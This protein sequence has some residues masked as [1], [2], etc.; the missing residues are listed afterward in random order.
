MHRPKEQP[1]T[2]NLVEQV[3]EVPFYIPATGPST[4]P[5]RNLK[6]DDC[7]AIFDSHGDIGAS[8]GGPDGLYCRDTR[9][10]GHLELLLN[11]TQLLLLGSNV[12]DDNA[13]LTVD[14]TNPDIYF[15][16][17]LVLPKDTLHLVRT[18]FLWN[19][20][21][22]QRVRIHNHGDR[23]VHCVVGMSYSSDFADLFEVR[24]MRRAKR[25]SAN[26]KI[27]GD[28]QVQL[29]YWGL[30]DEL[31]C[32]DLSFAPPPDR[33]S[34]A[35]ASYT[36][37][38]AP[39]EA[40]AID[41]T[42]ECRNDDRHPA[43]HPFRRG[44]RAALQER[45]LATRSTTTI[46]TSHDIFNEM[47]C[48]S[49]SD[50]AMLVTHTEQGPYPYA[51]IPWY[52]TTFGR[53]G[54]ITA[55]QTLW[56]CPDIARG[57]LRRLAALQAQAFDPLA[58]AEPGKILHEMR[59]GEMANL[60]E[61]PFKLYYGSV[62]STPLFVLLAGLYFERTGDLAL[63]RELWP[64][65]ERALEW[66]DG[67]GDPD[68]D[69]F[70]EY[71]RNNDDGLVNQGWKDS[72]DAIF[73]QD[74]SMAAGPIALCEVQGYVYAAKKHAAG[75]A[76]RFEK[77][78]L[79]DALDQAAD[80]LK[81]NFEA[82]FWCEDIG[83]Y[84][85]ALDG[86]KNPCRVRSSNAGQVLFSG[87]ASPDRA[88]MVALQMMQ[89]SFFSGWGI[90]TIGREEARYNPMSYHNG[91]VWPHDNSMIAAGFARYGH[92]AAV[93]RV[94]GGLF[95]AA[96]YMDLR[97][98]PELYCGFHR[99]RARGPTLYP[100]ACSPQAWAAGAPHQLIQSSLGIEF[101]PER[102]EI[103]LRNPELP[104]FIN[105]ITLRGLR[106]GALSVDITV[107]RQDDSVALRILRNDGHVKVSISFN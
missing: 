95:D 44:M 67:P 19:N 11:G 48:R 34:T 102:H 31:R 30:D 7:F 96:T 70:V 56:C 27:L 90:R 82:A 75:I 49:M 80:A 105:E 64:N 26:S 33:L 28:G 17:K 101:D 6:H 74:G 86:E 61:V 106:V 18:I 89:P 78:A 15:E 21:A 93:A 12:R 76:R 98:L 46:T 43:H 39:G 36:L 53:D 84:A 107:G 94:F 9:F 42:V 77:H 25:G 35:I 58:D 32:T 63:L 5:R 88:S 69:G 24:G 81:E 45:Q 103:V 20:T 57:V 92:K 54:I 55:I 38:L 29:Q 23:A 50:L 91:S 83:T 72:H 22:Y 1:S 41:L 40:K 37:S 68:E 10:L 104:S 16:N 65:I 47:I 4:R 3:A 14:L 59:S 71:H 60:R 62:D 52:S 99:A 13:L 66:I 2:V 51:G 8:P 79:A 100:V 85:I 97:R 87:I 73:H